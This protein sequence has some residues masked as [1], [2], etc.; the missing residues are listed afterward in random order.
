MRPITVTDALLDRNLLGAALGDAS[1]WS[2]WFAILK[3]AH[4]IQLT[5]DERKLFAAVSGDREPPTRKVKELV[6]IASRRPGKGR[7]GAGCPFRAAGGSQR[8][9]GAW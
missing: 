6:C 7:I 4:G 8:S 2:T 9:I 1:T 3:A 5:R